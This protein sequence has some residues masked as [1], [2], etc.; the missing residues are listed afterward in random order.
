MQSQ[1]RLVE[2]TD[3]D[4]ILQLEA[5]V[6]ELEAMKKTTTPWQILSKEIENELDK[7]IEKHNEKH[8]VKSAITNILGKAFYK[9]SVISMTSQECKDAEIFIKFA[10]DFIQ[11]RR[12]EYRHN[13]K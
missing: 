2:I 6:A 1:L 12:S 8:Q 9:N 10:I 13:K 4:R 7:V 3:K 11:V 5:R